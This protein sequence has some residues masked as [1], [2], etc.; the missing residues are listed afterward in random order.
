MPS[1]GIASSKPDLFPALTI[2]ADHGN[3]SRFER[4][5]AARS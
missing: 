2:L 1:A 5:P 4:A 3:A